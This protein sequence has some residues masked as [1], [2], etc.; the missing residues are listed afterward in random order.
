MTLEPLSGDLRAFA[1][2]PGAFV[3]IGPDEERIP[4]DRYSVTFTPGEQFWSH[5]WS[6]SGSASAISRVESPRSRALLVEGVVLLLGCTLGRCLL[7]VHEQVLCRY[8]DRRGLAVGGDDR[9]RD[10]GAA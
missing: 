9:A 3:A 8:S 5:R 7:G 4:T 10:S 1:E 6:G 2:D